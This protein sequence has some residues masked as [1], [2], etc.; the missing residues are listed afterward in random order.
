MVE[1]PS[2]TPQL[3]RL[4]LIDPRADEDLVR[5][6]TSVRLSYVQVKCMIDE[7]Q[8]M[9]SSCRETHYGGGLV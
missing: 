9:S 5:N 7:V 4:E 1:Q 8:P 2:R 6:Q 3:G